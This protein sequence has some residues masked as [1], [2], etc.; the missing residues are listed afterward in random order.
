MG[1]TA[2]A[3][4]LVER[5]LLINEIEG[6]K[7]FDPAKHSSIV[8]DEVDLTSLLRARALA[9]VEYEWPRQVHAR[10]VDVDIPARVPKIFLSNMPDVF[11]RDFT[12]AIASRVATWHA[13]SPLFPQ[14]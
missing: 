9:I 6:L 1:K 8:F 13:P 5:P 7:Q 14:D 10:Y 2:L 3:L 4:T 11:P 12:G